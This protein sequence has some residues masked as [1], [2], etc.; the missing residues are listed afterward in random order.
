MRGGS[1]PQQDAARLDVATNLP[2]AEEIGI[3]V[4]PNAGALPPEIK[5]VSAIRGPTVLIPT[6]NATEDAGAPC[7]P[8]VPASRVNRG[9]C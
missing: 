5:E 1:A 7:A 3:D 8:S 2:L 6:A 9:G 4:E